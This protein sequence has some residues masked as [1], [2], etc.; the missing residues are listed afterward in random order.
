MNGQIIV[1]IDKPLATVT[2]SR[3]DKLNSVTWE[4]LR[5]FDKEIQ[6]LLENPNILGIV[7]T[8]EGDKAFTAGFDLNTIKGL[9]GV[10]H[11]NFFKLLDTSIARLRENASCITLASCNGYTIGFGAIL[12][13]AC[14]FRF[15]SDNAL[16]RLPEID[17]DVFPGA[18][19]ASGL[20]HLVGPAKAKDILI[21]GR[22]VQ[23]KEAYSLGIADRIVKQDQ[24]F[25]ESKVYLRE[26]TTKNRSILL[27]TK[28]AIDEMVEGGVNQDSKIETDYFDRWL[29]DRQK[30][31]P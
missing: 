27:N 15:F 8:G 23:A 26:I 29:Q 17:L 3:P 12:A 25:Q 6:Q 13:L 20:V 10:D 21:T 5:A 16:F 31:T 28:K 19:A 1:E 2:I 14:D 4:M 9:R 18:G 24:L 30:D 22:K 7:F 11:Y